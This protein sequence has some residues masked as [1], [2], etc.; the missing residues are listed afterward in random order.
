MFELAKCRCRPK[1]VGRIRGRGDVH[2]ARR[3]HRHPVELDREPTN[4]DLGDTV[5][6]ERVDD[7]ALGVV[8]FEVG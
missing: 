5:F 6:L 1:E 2:V 7:E 4:D 3:G 8:T